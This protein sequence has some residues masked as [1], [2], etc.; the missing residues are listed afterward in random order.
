MEFLN[1]NQN[2]KLV[3]HKN[4]SENIVSEMRPFFPGGDELMFIL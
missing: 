4:A 3:I 1:F 2:T